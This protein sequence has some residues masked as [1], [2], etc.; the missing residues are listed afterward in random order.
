[1]PNE[2]WPITIEIPVLWGD[3]DDFGHVNNIVYLKWFETARVEVAKKALGLEGLQ[4]DEIK[5]TN[6]FGPILANFKINYRIPLK[7]PDKVY[8]SARVKKNGIG[9]SSFTVEYLMTSEKNGAATVADGESVIVIINY[10]D[11]SKIKIDEE[12]KNQLISMEGVE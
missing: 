1:M 9:N 6:G 12:I 2:D 11:G 4:M 3:M 7:Y 8:A 5:K 10:R